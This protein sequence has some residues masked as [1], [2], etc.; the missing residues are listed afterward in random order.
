MEH[1]IS[2]RNGVSLMYKKNDDQID[3]KLKLEII[4][5]QVY[6]DTFI[7]FN[8]FKLIETLN[9]DIIEC[10]YMEQTDTLDTMNIC[11]VLKPIG[12]EFGLSQK[13]ILSRTNSAIK[14]IS[15]LFEIITLIRQLQNLRNYFLD[16]SRVYIKLVRD[17][18]IENP[19]LVYAVLKDV[20]I[21]T[22]KNVLYCLSSYN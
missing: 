15:S 6:M 9:T 13:Y 11:M 5:N 20:Y 1:E 22:L 7:D 12:K 17:K 16:I 3:F 14:K 18:S 21:E 8:I 4:N 2:N 19:G 10:I